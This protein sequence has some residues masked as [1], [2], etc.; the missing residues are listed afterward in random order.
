MLC[1]EFPR[2]RAK[3]STVPLGDGVGAHREAPGSV[4]R[5]RERKTGKRL[6]CS[7]HGKEQVSRISRFRMG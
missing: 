2:A 3:R 7:F 6:Y 5:Q 4:G 1:T